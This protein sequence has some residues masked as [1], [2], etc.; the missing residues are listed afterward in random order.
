MEKRKR[1]SSVRKRRRKKTVCNV[2]EIS[3]TENSDRKKKNLK[4]NGKQKE[5]FVRSVNWKIY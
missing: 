3:K 5:I 4:S 2:S 1:K